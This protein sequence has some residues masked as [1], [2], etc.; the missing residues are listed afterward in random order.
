MSTAERETRWVVHQQGR[1]QDAELTQKP[2]EVTGASAN[3]VRRFVETYPARKGM[4]S[5]VLQLCP[6]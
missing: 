3:P 1:Q 4:Q 2:E 6:G 5:P